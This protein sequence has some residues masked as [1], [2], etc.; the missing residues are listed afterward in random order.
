MS[1]G[2][3]LQSLLALGVATLCASFLYTIAAIL[4]LKWRLHEHKEMKEQQSRHKVENKKWLRSG[5]ED[6]LRG[7]GLHY[8]PYGGSVSK[9]NKKSLRDRRPKWQRFRIA[10]ELSIC[11]ET[12]SLNFPTSES[13]PL[14]TTPLHSS[15]SPYSVSSPRFM[16]RENSPERSL[17]HVAVRSDA[18]RDS[19]LQK[20]QS[21]QAFGIIK[22]STISKRVTE[23]LRYNLV[24][25]GIRVP[26]RSRKNRSLSQSDKSHSSDNSKP[27]SNTTLLSR[28]ALADSQDHHMRKKL[29]KF[30]W[31]PLEFGGFMRSTTLGTKILETMSMKAPYLVKATTTSLQIK[32]EPWIVGNEKLL[33]YFEISWRIV[34]GQNTNGLS[35]WSTSDPRYTGR[36]FQSSLN[37]TTS[38][39]LNDDSES[40]ARPSNH[41]EFDACEGTFTPIPQEASTNPDLRRVVTIHGLPAGCPLVEFRVRSMIMLKE[42]PGVMRHH[43]S[44]SSID[45]GA[46]L[47]G[48]YSM[49]SS[50]A[51]TLAATA[52][53]PI[54]GAITSGAIELRWGP[55]RD[56]RYGRTE[57]YKLMGKKAGTNTFANIRSG[58]RIHSCSIRAINSIPLTA[59]TT[60]VFKLIVRT[61]A[62]ELVSNS[63]PVTTLPAPP[64]TPMAPIVVETTAR[65]IELHWAAPSDNGSPIIRYILYGRRHRTS[66]FKRL[67]TGLAESFV[68]GSRTDADQ[69]A[70]DTLYV[71]K[72][73]AIN[74]YGDSPASS[75][76]T[77]R[78]TT[79]SMAEAM[80]IASGGSATMQRSP[81]GQQNLRTARVSPAGM[82][83][84]PTH[85]SQESTRNMQGPPGSPAHSQHNTGNSGQPRSPLSASANS[86]SSP[87]SASAASPDVTSSRAGLRLSSAPARVSELPNGWV[88]CWDPQREI[89]YYFNS[90]T[91]I[92]QWIH[93]IHG[94]GGKDPDLEFRK[95][96]FK[97]LYSLRERDW[98][99]GGRKILKMTLRRSHLVTDSFEAIRR[100]DASKLKLK[101]KIIFLGEEGIDSGG[102]TKEWFL[103]LSRALLDPQRCLFVKL[104]DS[105]LNS[106]ATSYHVDH[107]SSVNEHHLQYFHFLGNFLAKAIYDRQLVDLPLCKSI[108]KYLLGRPATLKDLQEMDP[109][110][111]KSLVWM[112]SND[113]DDV[114]FETFTV[115]VENFG[116]L[117]EIELIPG[118]REIKV[119]NANKDRYVQAVLDWKTTGAVAKQLKSMRNGFQEVLPTFHIR[120][121]SENEIN[122]LLN[123][124]QDFDISE[125][126]QATRY[127]GGFDTD[128]TAV[129]I[130][131]SVVEK[132]DLKA[133]GKLLQFTTGSSKVPLDGYDPCFTITKSSAESG[134]AALPTS[135]T[136]FNQLVLPEYESEE[137]MRK[138]LM[139]A[140]ENAGGFH[141]T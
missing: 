109:L 45:D 70:P 34:K 94:K 91:G 136:C 92:T 59:D 53:P 72:L 38:G 57:G 1:A 12:F 137:I 4:W 81:T 25:A 140:F 41:Y 15:N 30:G 93:P 47:W 35:G 119:T 127:T 61:S 108:Y 104:E 32:W 68:C 74:S 116:Q 51:Q 103:E 132:L 135:H 17:Y 33:K 80:S 10:H 60:Y 77:A 44:S 131:W 31:G 3:T 71:F 90:L 24:N 115:S 88:E 102:L 111:H 21:Q 49:I 96:R 36:D 23:A 120:E 73:K 100:L 82:H 98:P 67:F 9:Q 19:P 56:P 130:F 43:G 118:G 125:M 6:D 89:C 54:T 2:N 138:K 20:G 117:Q 39:R 46:V 78:T 28:K 52:S 18:D 5:A 99:Q 113:I 87:G 122:L 65:T 55:P 64:D 16:N 66:R 110:Y 58:S 105:L 84:S 11:T 107:R 126:R 50:P 69:L 75:I 106:G 123:G 134:T 42:T 26:K 86:R 27:R 121:F 76:V 97:L 139:Y 133:R 101:T 85:T 8:N 40:G 83:L 114:I 124:K 63:L 29:P 37:D 128:S 14:Q 129:N 62:G 7:H 95:K 22:P 112:L 13:R 48:P 79:L 141:M